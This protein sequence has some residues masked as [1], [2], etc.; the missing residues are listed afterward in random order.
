LFFNGRNNLLCVVI[1]KE[2]ETF[3]IFTLFG[4][5]EHLPNPKTILQDIKKKSS[6][7]GSIVMAIVPNAYSLY[8][9]FLQEKSV[10]FDG[11]NHLMYF[12]DKTLRKLFE[13][14][15]LT[16]LHQDTILTGISNIKRQMQWLDPYSDVS[17][18]NY[19]PERIL[20][21]F[22]NNKAEDLII[23]NNLGLRLR[24]IAQWE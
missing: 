12:S 19:I 18:S 1:R 6:E 9:M 14:C 5:L 3:D 13:N 16:I 22:D 21:F 4:V 2:N 10:R 7:K 15:G 8:H 20:P 17:D 24:I 23:A 11:R